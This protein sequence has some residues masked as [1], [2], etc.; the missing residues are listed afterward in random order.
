MTVREVG[1]TTCLV[2]VRNKAAIV[3]E[4]SMTRGLVHV[5]LEIDGSSSTRGPQSERSYRGDP[6]QNLGGYR[7]DR[8]QSSA[9]QRGDRI[10]RRGRN[11]SDRRRIRG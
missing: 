7:Y 5:R 9:L 1:T 10:H 4:A 6:N 2:C 3:Q 11:G 8:N